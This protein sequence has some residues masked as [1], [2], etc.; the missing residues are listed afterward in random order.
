MP[1]GKEAGR[2][3]VLLLPPGDYRVESWSGESPFFGD[4]GNGYHVRSREFSLRFAAPAGK[5]RY[6]GN[7]H[8]DFPQEMDGYILN[9]RYRIRTGERG[10]RDL[11][12]FRARYPRLA[13]RPV[14]TRLIES[15]VNGKELQFYIDN[16]QD[17]E[18]TAPV[19]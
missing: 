17:H 7:V 2:V 9:G 5:I 18:S 6:V 14:D 3:V 8:F 16:I 4:P 15:G 12:V 11:E 10:R 1:E 19:N 13:G